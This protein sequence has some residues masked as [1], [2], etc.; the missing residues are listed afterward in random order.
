MKRAVVKKRKAVKPHCGKLFENLEQTLSNNFIQSLFGHNCDSTDC[1][2]YFLPIRMGGLNI[3]NPTQTSDHYYY[4]SRTA[5]HLLIQSIVHQ[6]PF[7][8]TGYCDHVQQSHLDSVQSL[9]E[10]HNTT[11]STILNNFDN[12]SKRAILHSQNCISSWLNT[13]PYNT[14]S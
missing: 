8:P 5:T 11:F 7:I 3:K 9:Q 12:N 1:L 14:T 4:S 10:S 13:I 6:S 2:L